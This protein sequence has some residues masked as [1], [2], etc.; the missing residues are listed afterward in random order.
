MSNRFFPS[1]PALIVTSK[2]GRRKHPVDGVEKMHNGVDMVA[3]KDGKTGQVDKI[4]AH[5]G[6]TV[7]AVGYDASAG[8]FV[9]IKVASDSVMVYY[10]LKNKSTLKV[11]QTVKK[12]EVVGYMGKTGTATGAHLHWG[13]KRNGEWIDPAPYL[14]ADY[15]VAPAV[16]Y[17]TLEVPVL[18]QGSKGETVK[19]MQI[20][21]D[22]YGYKD[23]MKES[24]YGSFGGKT[25]K[26]LRRYQKDHGLAAD[27][28]C[29][30]ATWA[31][32]M[33]LEGG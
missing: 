14:D 10:H 27:G 30:P 6:G 25:D 24:A 18:K 11:G 22:S 32:L 8:N 20:L 4:L 21:L 23:E 33:G 3:T 13:I 1:Y 7:S 26:A 17:I 16:K 2:F 15:P 19:A 5:T 29:G 31:S 9:Q 12:G 28:S